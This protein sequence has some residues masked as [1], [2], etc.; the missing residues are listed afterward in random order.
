M[1]KKKRT[2]E[3][4]FQLLATRR[5]RLG[6]LLKLDVPDIILWHEMRLVERS[7]TEVYGRGWNRMPIRSRIA[8]WWKYKV[9][10]K[11]L[12]A[13]WDKEDAEE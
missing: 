4:A 3:E 1:R 11:A 10:V 9:R 6:R 12:W 2:E 5:A 7:Q 13:K 8:F